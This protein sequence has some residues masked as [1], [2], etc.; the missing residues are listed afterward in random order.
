MP[1]EE[2]GTH[3]YASTE[4][5]PFINV[6]RTLLPKLLVLLSNGLGNRIMSGGSMKAIGV[7]AVTVFAVVF[8]GLIGIYHP[9]H[10]YYSGSR[11]HSYVQQARGL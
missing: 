11:G 6:K 7:V 4:R 9:E 5:S 10:R 1:Q 8:V 3:A 2:N